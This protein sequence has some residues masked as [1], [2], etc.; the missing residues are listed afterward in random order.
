MLFET[1]SPNYILQLCSTFV[2]VDNDNKVSATNVTPLLSVNIICCGTTTMLTLVLCLH[3]MWMSF[4]WQKEIF[5]LRVQTQNLLYFISNSSLAPLRLNYQKA[6]K[7]S[8]DQWK[9]I[10]WSILLLTDD[11]THF[12]LPRVIYC[13]LWNWFG[14]LLILLLFTSKCI[15]LNYLWLKVSRKETWFSI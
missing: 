14:V 9:G 12:I 6:I 4:H 2:M 8:Y 5:Q 13:N 11:D 15:L 3:L 10:F 1:R 7:F